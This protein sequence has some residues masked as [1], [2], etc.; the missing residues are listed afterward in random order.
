MAAAARRAE[1]DRVALVQHVL[2]LGIGLLAVDVQLARRAVLAALDAEGREDRALGEEGH[3]DRR[4]AAALDQDLLP[5]PAAM[6]AG[7]ARVGPQL[8]VM[9]AQRRDVLADLD[10]GRGDVGRPATGR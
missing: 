2:L 1:R 6:T 8:L 10:R 4:L 9:E 7:A 3:R 5:Q